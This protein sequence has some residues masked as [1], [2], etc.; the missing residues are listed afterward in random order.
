MI[1]A[2]GDY[3]GRRRVSHRPVP[4]VLIA[5]LIVAVVAGLALVVALP[6]RAPRDLPWRGG[7]PVIPVL[8]L[9]PPPTPSAAPPSASPSVS[10]SPS[11]SRTSPSVKRSP[12]PSRPP[13]LVFEAE[14]GGRSGPMTIRSV[15]GASGGRVVTGIGDGRALVFPAVTVPA[16]GE[17]RL[18]IAYASDSSRRCYIGLGRRWTQLTF[19]SSGGANKVAAIFMTVR[20]DQGRNTVEA[21]NTS[22]RWC[23]DLDRIT[24]TPA[25]HPSSATS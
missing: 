25:D 15:P 17:Y 11:R 14:A 10:A 18:T 24:V 5:V 2:P 3:L 19:P 20:F 22:G 6:D 8:S 23:P 16:K 13:A 7:D 4:L 9:E 12:S 1:D 21:G